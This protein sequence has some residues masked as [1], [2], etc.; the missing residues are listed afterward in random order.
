MLVA[1]ASAKTLALGED[2]GQINIRFPEESP[3]GVVEFILLIAVALAWYVFWLLLNRWNRKQQSF[4][5]W[6]PT[7]MLISI[8]VMVRISDRADSATVLGKSLECVA[9]LIAWINFPFLIGG[10]VLG[11]VW[12]E[13]IPIWIRL[14]FAGLVFWALWHLALRYMRR[15]SAK[16]I[17]MALHLPNNMDR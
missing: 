2:L 10:G 1:I 9:V 12:L 17:V 7:I 4:C 6:F 16:N 14:T 13:I 15:R 5:Y 11:A 8:A 3:F